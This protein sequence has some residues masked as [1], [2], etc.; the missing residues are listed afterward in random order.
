[1][2]FLPHRKH[3]FGPPWPVMGISF[4][5]LFTLYCLMKADDQLPHIISAIE[6]CHYLHVA[7]LFCPYYG[8]AENRTYSV[9]VHMDVG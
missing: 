2:M 4:L 7:E 9:A 3:N 5:L 1:M 6:G 8:D